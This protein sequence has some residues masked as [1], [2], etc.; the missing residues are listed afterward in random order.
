MTFAD[1]VERL[2]AEK[3]TGKI[4]VHLTQG[5]PVAVEFPKA[6]EVV[7]LERRATKDSVPID[8]TVK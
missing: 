4:T 3:R 5:V 6:S 8:I 2:H 7:P 1:L